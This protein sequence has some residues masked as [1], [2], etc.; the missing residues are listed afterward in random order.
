M[1]TNP[2]KYR[3][4]ERE[5]NGLYRIEALMDFGKVKAGDIKNGECVFYFK[6]KFF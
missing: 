6:R 4:L 5:H 1:K 2:P 3:L